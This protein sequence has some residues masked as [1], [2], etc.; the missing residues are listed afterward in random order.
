MG[1]LTVAKNG[2]A[3]LSIYV[4]PKASRNTICGVHDQALKVALTAPPVDNKA[5]KALIQFLSK[6]L[7]VRKGDIKLVSGQSS[8]RKV[9]QIS[10]TNVEELRD[11]IESIL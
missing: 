3:L 1:Y 5:N 2:C 4:Q 8:R 10:V 7:T 6:K 11:L 9:L